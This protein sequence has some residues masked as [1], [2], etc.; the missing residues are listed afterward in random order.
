MKRKLI[1]ICG[2]NVE[3]SDLSEFHYGM[4]QKIQYA[5]SNFLISKYN[6]ENQIAFTYLQQPS[7]WQLTFLLF[8]G[9][10]F[11]EDKIYGAWNVSE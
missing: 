8:S 5:M 4:V 3:K 6:L 1:K 7:G 10:A 2:T 9:C 11:S